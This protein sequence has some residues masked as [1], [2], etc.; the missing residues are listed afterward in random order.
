MSTVA[1][2]RGAYLENPLEGAPSIEEAHQAAAVVGDTAPPL[3]DEE[4]DLYFVTF[5]VNGGGLWQLD[6]HRK[7]P[8]YHG[9]SSECAILQ[10]T[11][12]VVKQIVERSDSDTFNLI[13]LA[14]AADTVSHPTTA[15]RPHDPLYRTQTEEVAFFNFND[16]ID[17][18][19]A[20]SPNARE[21]RKV[22]SSLY[23]IHPRWEPTT[24]PRTHDHL[25]RTQ[26]KE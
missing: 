16:K 18:W 25:Y 4:I 12:T 10:D 1:K 7:G 6:G 11:A 2:A 5:V 8:V 3:A 9:P 21:R 24:A 19:Q 23:P 13:A 26:T 14:S 20:N 22:N 15:P 17:K